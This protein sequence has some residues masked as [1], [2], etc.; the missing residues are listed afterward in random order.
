MCPAPI[1]EVIK[2]QAAGSNPEVELLPFCVFSNANP[3][4]KVGAIILMD[5]VAINAWIRGSSALSSASVQRRGKKCPRARC[6][7]SPPPVTAAVPVVTIRW[8]LAAASAVAT[9][10][11]AGANGCTALPPPVSAT[12]PVVAFR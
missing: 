9:R 4:V 10:I 5:G 2:R 11:A 1:G 7:A 3:A 6:A 12:V 8:G